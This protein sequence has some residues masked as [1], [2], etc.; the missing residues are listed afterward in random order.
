MDR[1]GLA[2]DAAVPL[3]DTGVRERCRVASD[4]GAGQFLV[5]AGWGFTLGGWAFASLVVAGYTGIVRRH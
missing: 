3:V 1:V 4:T 2:I 5:A